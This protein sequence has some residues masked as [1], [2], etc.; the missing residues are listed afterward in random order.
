MLYY[1]SPLDYLK[2]LLPK[3]EELTVMA[4]LLL[5][6]RSILDPLMVSER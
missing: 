2:A 1:Y 6:R 3:I 5:E 4:D